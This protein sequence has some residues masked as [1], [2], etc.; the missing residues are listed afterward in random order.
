ME[1]HQQSSNGLSFEEA[2]LQATRG[3]SRHDASTNVVA[4]ATTADAGVS[5]RRPRQHGRI[6]SRNE[7]SAPVTL[8]YQGR[9]LFAQLQEAGAIIDELWSPQRGANRPLRER[10]RSHWTPPLPRRRYR[11]QGGKLTCRRP[12]ASLLRSSTLVHR[13]RD[14]TNT[15]PITM[16]HENATAPLRVLSIFR[17]VNSWHPGYEWVTPFEDFAGLRAI[18]RARNAHAVKWNVTRKHSILRA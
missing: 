11:N 5:N 7:A 15:H 13:I 4:V 9:P 14:L 12:A 6:T 2:C 18:T 3:I 1:D 10:F 16:K 17:D 8:Q